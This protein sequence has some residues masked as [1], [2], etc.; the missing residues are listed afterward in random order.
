MIA[1]FLCNKVWG[2]DEI[3][4][5]QFKVNT[6]CPPVTGELVLKRRWEHCLWES[7]CDL[8]SGWTVVF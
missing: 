8:C 5:L 1:N 6:T 4:S 7:R 2:F 3:K